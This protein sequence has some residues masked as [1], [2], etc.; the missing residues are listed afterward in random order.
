MFDLIY[1]QVDASEHDWAEVEQSVA[2][3]RQYGELGAQRAGDL[4]HRRLNQVGPLAI[5]V[6]HNCRT[7][8]IAEANAGSSVGGGVECQILLDL[9]GIERNARQNGLPVT[10]VLA[11]TLVHEQE[12]CI[13]APDDRELPAVDQEHH[14]ASK[15]GSAALLDWVNSEYGKL[16]PAGYWKD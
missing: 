14:L 5:E 13:H 11:S 7:D 4:R 6:C 10:W 3:V 8:R 12:H 9:S 1:A 2:M 16:T 15:I